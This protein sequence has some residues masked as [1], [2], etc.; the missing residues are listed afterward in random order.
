[1]V[2]FSVF[3]F[4]AAPAHFIFERDLKSLIFLRF[5]RGVSQKHGF[6]LGF[7][8]VYLKMGPHSPAKCAKT[9]RL[10]LF[11]KP[12]GVLHRIPSDPPDPPDPAE[13]HHGWPHRPWVLHAGGQDDGS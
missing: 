13:T 3:S 12:P 5:F 4:P 2:I 6:C 9:I 11:F 10:L 7:L 8:K 1:M